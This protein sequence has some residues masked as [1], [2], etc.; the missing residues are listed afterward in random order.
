MIIRIFWVQA[1]TNLGLWEY[2][3]VVLRMETTT[4]TILPIAS[5]MTIRTSYSIMVHISLYSCEN[6]LK[7]LQSH[8]HTQIILKPLKSLHFF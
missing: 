6:L 8:S 7:H 4:L 1:E 2:M 3:K 5:N